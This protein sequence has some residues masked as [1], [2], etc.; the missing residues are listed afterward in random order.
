MSIKASTKIRV[1][2]VDDSAVAR[3]LLEKGLSSYPY[4]EIVGKAS[5][6]WTA[7]DKIVLLHPDVVT[8]DIEMPGMNGTEFLTKLIPQYPIPVIVVSGLTVAGSEQALKA[9]QAGALDVVS[10]P[11]ASTPED[12]QRMLDE[13][14][15][16][17]QAAAKADIRKLQQSSSSSRKQQVQ[18]PSKEANQHYHGGLIAIGASTGGTTVL[19]SIIPRLPA[20]SPPVLIVQ[21]MPPVFTRLFAESLDRSSLVTV[22][23]AED[24]MR[25]VPGLVLV[26]P[27][28]K[29]L[30]VEKSGVYRIARCSKGQKING[31]CP[32]V[33]VLFACLALLGA[34][35][36]SALLLTGMGRDGAE[37][38]LQLRKA[39]ARCFAQ[40]EESSV[41]FG[42]PA[43]AW[44]LGAAEHLLDIDKM[45]PTLLDTFKEKSSK[46]RVS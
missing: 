29:H 25:I 37:G 45:I 41:V 13:L 24:G 7:R 26:A 12:L 44:K 18:K 28:D 16:K 5:D 31:H 42:M 6:A 27:G 8:L 34:K 22:K 9:M 39:G 15:E 1:L 20:N 14:S 35:D 46:T 40:N 11:S 2:I 30:T 43:E 33:D 3:A 21:H 36:V 38:L 17:I 10:K 4:I 32:S 23:E 19:N